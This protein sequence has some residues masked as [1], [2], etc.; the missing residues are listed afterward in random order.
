MAEL[1][2]N[3]GN[4]GGGANQGGGA[5]QFI[6][7]LQAIASLLRPRDG[8]APAG[9]PPAGQASP[10][11][12]A[13]GQAPSFLEQLADGIAELIG[14]A[15]GARGGGTPGGT[16]FFNDVPE[17]SP[18]KPFFLPGGGT[19]VALNPTPGPAP[20]E[21][22]I[23]ASSFNPFAAATAAVLAGGEAP[24]FTIQGPQFATGTGADKFLNNPLTSAGALAKFKAAGFP[25]PAFNPMAFAAAFNAR[26][27][28]LIR[29]IAQ[30]N[31]SQALARGLVPG[32]APKTLSNP[33]GFD[34]KFFGPG[35]PAVGVDL[36][37]NKPAAQALADLQATGFD[38]SMFRGR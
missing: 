26:Q 2:Q 9:G 19:G 1:L 4:T 5:D 6:K 33:A 8:A 23:T 16:Q 7:L 21:R 22:P 32:V 35:V 11:I 28:M 25:D 14:E 24:A 31:L 34:P 13:P 12:A 15:V 10:G 38:T 37:A 29:D 3:L 20:G 18:G 27:Q 36:P 30:S 17:L